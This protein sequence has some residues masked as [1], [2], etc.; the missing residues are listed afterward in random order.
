MNGKKTA[1]EE[2]LE[3]NG[4]LGS[5]VLGRPV[6]A[7]CLCVLLIPTNAAAGLNVI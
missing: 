6:G 7:T 2:R 3:G 1:V 5:K 4:G